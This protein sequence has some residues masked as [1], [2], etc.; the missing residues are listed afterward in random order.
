VLEDCIVVMRKGWCNRNEG[1]P[2]CSVEYEHS[3]LQ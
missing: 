1:F 3:F 2:F